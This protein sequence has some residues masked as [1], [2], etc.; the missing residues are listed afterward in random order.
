MILWM[1][2]SESTYNNRRLGDKVDYLKA[3]SRQVASPA[4][5]LLW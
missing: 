2:E 3:T 4:W 5:L 1:G